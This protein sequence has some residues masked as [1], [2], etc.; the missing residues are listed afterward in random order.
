MAE[1]YGEDLA[2]VRVHPPSVDFFDVER[3]VKYVIRVAV[4]NVSH[5]AERVRFV[6][7]PAGSGFT[8]LKH[9]TATIAPG[10]EAHAEVEFVLAADEDYH[11]TLKVDVSGKVVELPLHAYRPRAQL[12]LET[13]LSFGPVVHENVVSRLLRVANRGKRAAKV[14]FEVAMIEAGGE[15]VPQAQLGER[16]L[17]TIVPETCE[18]GPGEERELAVELDARALG[19]ARGLA[20]LSISGGVGP[21]L[22]DLSGNRVELLDA[23]GVLA[24]PR[25]SFGQL[26]AGLERKQTCTLVNNGPSSI[27]F[28]FAS[29]GGDEEPQELAED[30]ELDRELSDA[31]FSISPADGRIGPFESLQLSFAFKPPPSPPSKAGF[32]ATRAEE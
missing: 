6:A 11:S 9:S 27:A 19:P 21:S 31:V 2:G 14:A 26:Y 12:E 30:E 18:I 23:K 15:E 13:V 24:P 32:R 22:V 4:K 10:I 8:V 29:L 5:R 16:S 1:E 20:R 17:F 7:P 25:L 28:S 3:G